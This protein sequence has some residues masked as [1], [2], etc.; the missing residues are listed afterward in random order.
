MGTGNT[1]VNGSVMWLPIE[2]GVIAI[3]SMSSMCLK[4]KSAILLINH[5]GSSAP[6]KRPG[7]GTG[8]FSL[9]ESDPHQTLG[10]AGRSP[11]LPE[12]LGHQSHS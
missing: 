7:R 1:Q 11:F 4:S 8:R 12:L 6:L 10:L 3:I 5:P 9:A 2:V